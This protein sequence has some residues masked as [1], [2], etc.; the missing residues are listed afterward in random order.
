MTELAE[1]LE[2]GGS[3][4]GKG[5]MLFKKI[6]PYR[7][8]RVASLMSWSLWPSPPR[9]S[10]QSTAAMSHRSSSPW[11]LQAHHIFG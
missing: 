10:T 1:L 8:V 4:M 3:M 6:G 2:R 7:L 5:Y 11:I 9:E